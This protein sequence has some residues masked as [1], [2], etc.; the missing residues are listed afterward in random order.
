VSLTTELFPT[1][2]ETPKE[3]SYAERR[4]RDAMMPV[5]KYVHVV[6]SSDA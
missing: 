1:L 2:K 6:F 3:S 5:G 4:A